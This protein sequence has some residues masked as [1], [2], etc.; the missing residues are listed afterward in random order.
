MATTTSATSSTVNVP[1]IV[2]SLGQGSGMDVKKLASDLVN[3]ERAP[4]AALIQK[5]IDSSK[6]EITGYGGM[7]FV[8]SEFKKSFDA[9][10]DSTDFAGLTVKNSQSAAFDVQ[11][12]ASAVPAQH[13]VT[14]TQVA[15]SQRSLTFAGYADKNSSVIS[16][17]DFTLTLTVGSKTPV[18]IT[19]PANSTLEGVK[20]AINSANA[21][22]TAQIIDSGIV[23]DTNRYQIM[24]TGQPGLANA[25]TMSSS[26]SGVGFNTTLGS[27]L[28]SAKDALLN[29]DGVNYSRS[30]NEISDIIPG[31]TLSL[32]SPTSGAASIQFARDT[33]A[34]K[35]KLQ[36][37]VSAYNDV[38]QFVGMSMDPKSTDPDFGGKLVG[39][40]TVKS[41]NSKLKQMVFGT[42]GG[43]SNTHIQGLRDL[44]IKMQDD[45]TLTLDETVFNKNSTAYYDEAVQMLSGSGLKNEFGVQSQGVGTRMTSWMKTLMSAQGPLLQNSQSAEKKVT[46]YETQLAKLQTRMDALLK[47]YNEQFANMQSIVGKTK[48]MQ[49]SLTSTFDGMMNAYKN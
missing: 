48:S 27:T 1:D 35:T 5:K 14:I 23:G 24:L 22:I 21:G 34:L 29:V 46:G 7:M 18:P 31:V 20:D 42:A 25:F 16:G 4:A 17:S 30:S 32:V 36:A 10:D 41:I 40:T 38:H 6:G 15:K 44:G 28:Q 45:G 43:T 39:N 19:V 37:M 12:T 47:R 26:I 9:I 49:T 33:S 2:T 8:L 3:A 13:D 11:T